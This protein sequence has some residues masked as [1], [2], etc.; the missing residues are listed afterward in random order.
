MI[1]IVMQ[2]YSDRLNNNGGNN[3]SDIFV[4]E[5][6]FGDIG[7]CFK[8]NKHCVILNGIIFLFDD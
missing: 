3:L 5:W 1:H 8:L 2:N 4:C 7:Y 6:V